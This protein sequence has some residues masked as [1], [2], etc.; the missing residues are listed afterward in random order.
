MFSK[1]STAS[2]GS[3][4]PFF[5][6]SRDDD[7]LEVLFVTVANWGR[8]ALTVSEAGI[9]LGPTAAYR[10]KPRKRA[11]NR[12]R[13]TPTNFAFEGEQTRTPVRLE[14]FDSCLFIYDAEP[15]LST[16]LGNKQP[17]RVL[18]GYALVAGRHKAAISKESMSV[19]DG[20]VHLSEE[21]PSIRRVI[22]AALDRDRRAD[23]SPAEKVGYSPEYLAW[24]VWR[25]MDEGTPLGQA[26]KNAI[27][28]DEATGAMPMLTARMALRKHGYAVDLDPNA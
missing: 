23:D 5:R 8:T 24:K 22:Y 15:A 6:H 9:D 11:R 19:P 18:R 14:P 21:K 16:E 12:H 13:V 7:Y 20:R 25:A 10:W 27:N 2:H 26:L 17:V 1:Q 4:N 28:D 3:N